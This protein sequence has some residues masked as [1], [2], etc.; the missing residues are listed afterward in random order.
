[1]ADGTARAMTPPP[2]SSQGRVGGGQGRSSLRSPQQSP[3][4]MREKSPS[5]G[6]VSSE[7]KANDL[8]TEGFID[9][10]FDELLMAAVGGGSI[11]PPAADEAGSQAEE[12]RSASKKQFATPRLARSNIQQAKE[13]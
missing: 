3:R 1:M 10:E 7:Q 9:L 2:P 6:L 8:D 11:G 5:A 12:P 13:S 4:G